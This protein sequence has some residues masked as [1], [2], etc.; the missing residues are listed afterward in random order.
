M[1]VPLTPETNP[2]LLLLPFLPSGTTQPSSIIS[3]QISHEAATV[4]EVDRPTPGKHLQPCL[5]TKH[6]PVDVDLE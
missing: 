2:F 4:C 1:R 5:I 3:V 6:W